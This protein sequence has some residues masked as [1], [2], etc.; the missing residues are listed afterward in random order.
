MDVFAAVQIVPFD[1]A[2]LKLAGHRETQMRID[3][4]H[5]NMCRFDLETQCDQDN[6]KKVQRRMQMMCADALV[7]SLQHPH[8]GKSESVKRG[9]GGLEVPP[10]YVI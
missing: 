4:D 3:A 1:S 7:G 2:V 10:G 8:A 6:Y 5:S 9:Y